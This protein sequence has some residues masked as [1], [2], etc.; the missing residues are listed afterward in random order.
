VLAWRVPGCRDVVNG[1]EVIEPRAPG[2]EV[3]LASVVRLVLAQ[4]PA[5]DLGGIAIRTDG[6]T[7]T[8]EGRVASEAEARL[9]ENDA[10]AVFGVDNVRNKIVVQ[11][12]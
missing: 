12:R 3:P 8:L 6:R 7:V 11:A 1:L 4:E 5:L 2:L 9:A 10:W